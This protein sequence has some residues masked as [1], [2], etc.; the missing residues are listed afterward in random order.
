MKSYDFD[1]V[2]YDGAVYCCE[3]V[4]VDAN[5]EDIF[6][7][8]ADEELDYYPVCDKCGHEHDYMSLTSYG[9]QE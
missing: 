8:F 3:C 1:A 4:P 2:T 7:I 6:P 5:P 9:L